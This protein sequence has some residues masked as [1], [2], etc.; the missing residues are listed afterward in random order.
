[1]VLKM[2]E[3]RNIYRNIP[4]FP[5]LM[6]MFTD[7]SRQIPKTVFESYVKSMEAYV[8]L[9]EKWVS[10][11]RVFEKKW[12]E[13][14]KEFSKEL[15]EKKGEKVTFE[16][17]YRTWFKTFSR[18]YDELLKSDEFARLQS[19]VAENTAEF[20]KYYR[21]SWENYLESI[22]GFPLPLRRE[23]NEVEKRL[24]ELTRKVRDLSVKVDELLKGK[25]R[26]KG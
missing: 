24:Q 21:E 20:I 12:N 8:K 16:D 13:A 6:K 15:F 7:Y 17:F 9:A 3:W 14:L 2:E 26:V 19:E 23:M 25:E 10:F 5:Q 4:G 11:Q 1:M 22:P 18:F